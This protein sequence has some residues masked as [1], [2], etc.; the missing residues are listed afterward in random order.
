MLTELWYGMGNW[1]HD[2]G[3]M[4]MDRTCQ[5]GGIVVALSHGRFWAT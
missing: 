1:E 3:N 2:V 5:D 4:G